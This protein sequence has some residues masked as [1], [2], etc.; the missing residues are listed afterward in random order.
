[1]LLFLQYSSIT[2]NPNDSTDDKNNG[3]GGD[4]FMSIGLA[5]VALP[6]SFKFNNIEETEESRKKVE[7]ER[8]SK[9]GK[10]GNKPKNLIPSGIAPIP[11]TGTA[12]CVF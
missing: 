2:E 4:Q 3:S 1:M 5:E 11:A 12:R 8:K 9:Y 7:E 6:I 10:S